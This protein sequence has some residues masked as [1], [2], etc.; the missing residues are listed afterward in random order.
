M[1]QCE[2]RVVYV[3]LAMQ[4]TGSC[5]WWS[6]P[7]HVNGNC[8]KNARASRLTEFGMAVGRRSMKV[9]K[10]AIICQ[11]WHLGFMNHMWD[12]VWDQDRVAC[13]TSCICFLAVA[14]QSWHKSCGA[15]TLPLLFSLHQLVHR[16]KVI[17]VIIRDACFTVLAYRWSSSTVW[18]DWWHC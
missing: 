16:S 15:C 14:P 5:L 9:W 2:A 18:F 6:L 17:F 8:V 4:P 1:R 3:L 11:E 13:A 10:G 12:H 7:C